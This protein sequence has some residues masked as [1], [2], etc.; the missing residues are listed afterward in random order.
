MKSVCLLLLAAAVHAASPH[1]SMGAVV[2]SGGYMANLTGVSITGAAEV[3]VPGANQ[4]LVKMSASSVNPIDFK[5][6]DGALKSIFPLVFPQTLGCDFV[7]TVSSL[8]EGCSAALRPGDRVWGCAGAG[9]TEGAWAE[10]LVVDEAKVPRPPGSSQRTRSLANAPVL[11]ARAPTTLRLPVAT[12]LPTAF[13]S[14]RFRTACSRTRRRPPFRSWAR[15]CGR[16]S[17][18]RALTGAR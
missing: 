12:C 10:Y 2:A 1:A 3:P 7:G 18:S 8:G 17:T 13:R 11:P 16:P 15:P 5:V 6:L 4:V 9:S 14:G